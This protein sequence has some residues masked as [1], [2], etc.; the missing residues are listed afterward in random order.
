MPPRIK[1]KSADLQAQGAKARDDT[2]RQVDELQDTIDTWNAELRELTLR[3]AVTAAATKRI[4]TLTKKIQGAEN[5]IMDLSEEHR[6]LTLQYGPRAHDSKQPVDTRAE[7]SL[8]PVEPLTASVT[9][10]AEPAEPDATSKRR[11]HDEG[12]DSRVFKYLKLMNQ[13]M[14]QRLNALEEKQS[15]RHSSHRPSRHSSSHSSRNSSKV[16]ATVYGDERTNKRLKHPVQQPPIE[17]MQIA[18]ANADGIAQLPL[19]PSPHMQHLDVR[20]ILWPHVTIDIMTS[21]LSNK[22]D[23]SKLHTLIPMEFTVTSDALITT[24]ADDDVFD[25]VAK[26]FRGEDY[27]TPKSVQVPKI[28]KHFPTPGHWIAALGTWMGVKSAF[29]NK[30]I[31]AASVAVHIGQIQRLT[32]VYGW[33]KVRN[34]EIA[35]YNRYHNIDEPPTLWAEEDAKFAS[36]YLYHSPP[37][38]YGKPSSFQAQH[39]SLPRASP[40]CLNDRIADVNNLCNRF[41]SGL[42][43]NSDTCKYIHRCNLDPTKCMGHHAAVNCFH[44]L[45]KSSVPNRHSYQNNHGYQNNKRTG[46]NAITFP[47]HRHQENSPPLHKRD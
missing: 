30:G 8:D 4:E 11:A 43:C 37:D 45:L 31:W 40:A 19:L 28:A 21:I 26:L 2:E 34:Y 35:F 7:K 38:K 16:S 27:D 33:A 17:Q 6:R 13:T 12:D 9:Q 23:I 10:S 25:R 5:R 42:S 47:P 29:A 32:S 20:H 44:N 24:P 41:N 22:I 3:G 15:S 36:H 18:P 1:L 46:S 14:N 39:P